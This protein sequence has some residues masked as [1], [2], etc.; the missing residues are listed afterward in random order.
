VAAEDWQ[1]GAAAQDLIRR[2]VGTNLVLG[3]ANVAL[4]FVLPAMVA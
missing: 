2:L 1:A 3:L 4:V